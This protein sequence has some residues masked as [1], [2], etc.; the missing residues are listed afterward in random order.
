MVMVE[1]NKCMINGI[2]QQQYSSNPPGLT[3]GSD[4]L[5]QILDIMESVIEVL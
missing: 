5:N 4:L 2:D 3:P 1:E